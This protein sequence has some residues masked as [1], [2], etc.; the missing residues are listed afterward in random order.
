RAVSVGDRML[1]IGCT[2]ADDAGS[3]SLVIALALAG[4][5]YLGASQG[6]GGGVGTPRASCPAGLPL[7]AV[8]P[9]PRRRGRRGR[10]VPRR[11]GQGLSQPPEN[12][13]PE[14][15]LRRAETSSVPLGD[16][17]VGSSDAPARR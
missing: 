6:H 3:D 12:V 10:G 15:I 14:S 11:R 4:A 1:D 5:S 13:R 17:A 7:P 9:L 8:R 16:L 2:R